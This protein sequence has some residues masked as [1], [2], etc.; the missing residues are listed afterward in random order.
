MI[1]RLSPRECAELEEADRGGAAWARV[2]RAA[3]LDGSRLVLGID[4]A[5]SERRIAEAA[6]LAI[7]EV[8]PALSLAA[9]WCRRRGL[10]LMAFPGGDGA[11]RRHLMAVG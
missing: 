11:D 5:P 4:N 6:G 8:A 1:D 2:L 10:L 9:R 7:P 3:F